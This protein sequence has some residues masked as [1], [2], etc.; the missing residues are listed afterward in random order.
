[1]QTY[2]FT[3]KHTHT[4]KRISVNR[5]EKHK[6]HKKNPENNKKLI[7][8]QPRCKCEVRQGLQEMKSNKSPGNDGSTVE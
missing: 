5:F 7:S 1:M 6:T 2:L 8:F 4:Q 3:S